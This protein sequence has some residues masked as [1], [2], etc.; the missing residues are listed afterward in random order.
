MQSREEGS[1]APEVH[2]SVVHEVPDA[3]ADQAVLALVDLGG[4]DDLLL[5]R[6]RDPP[7]HHVA[8]ALVF[9]GAHD[10]ASVVGAQACGEHAGAP[11]PP[12]RLEDGVL[13]TLLL[14]LHL[15]HDIFDRMQGL[16]LARVGDLGDWR[17]LPVRRIADATVVAIPDSVD[18][19]IAPHCSTKRGLLGDLHELVEVDPAATARALLAQG[20][21]GHEVV[22]GL[23]TNAHILLIR[24]VGQANLL[25]EVWVLGIILGAVVLGNALLLHVLGA[26]GGST[27]RERAQA[28]GQ[29]VDDCELEL[30]EEVTELR[31]PLHTD[32]ARTHDE[33]RGVLVFQRLD[34]AILLQDVPAAALQKSLI[35]VGPGALRPSRLV[36]SREP[37]RLAP[38]VERAEVAPRSDHAVVEINLLRRRLEHRLDRGGLVRIAQLR[39]LAPDELAIH[40]LF[41]DR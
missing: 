19:A 33:N 15:S 11:G 34:G 28:L 8:G 7:V 32:E 25:P 41:N 12:S 21:L 24:A 2:G 10:E 40:L 16:L 20:L 29:E 38:L 22:R 3:N 1:L 13:D 37:E 5:E 4:L 9:V 18:G 31:N 39:H 30:R 36:H 14:G 27:G 17:H 35:E 23:H 6:C 26:V